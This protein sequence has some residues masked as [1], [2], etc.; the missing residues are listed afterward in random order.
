MLSREN[1]KDVVK[2]ANDSNVNSDS[3][4]DTP[5]DTD[6]KSQAK[7]LSYGCLLAP[8]SIAISAAVAILLI[9]SYLAKGYFR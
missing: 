3:N 6:W 7:M 1:S 8:F 2:I 5:F 4:F 9:P